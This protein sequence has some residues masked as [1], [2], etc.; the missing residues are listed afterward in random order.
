MIVT[1]FTGTD[2]SI[3][4]ARSLG[5]NLSNELPSDVVP[6]GKITTF[7]F[8][9]SDLCTISIACF[10]ASLLP[11][12]INKTSTDLVIRPMTGQLATSDFD[13]KVVSKILPRIIMSN[14][15]I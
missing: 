2:I 12:F 10:A 4:L 13:R 15:E 1:H 14:Q 9:I 5:L 6:S 11:L 7:L 3:A 8:F